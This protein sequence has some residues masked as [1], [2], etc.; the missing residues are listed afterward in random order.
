MGHPSL[1][2]GAASTGMYFST[3]ETVQ[4]AL[5]VFNALNISQIDT[6][7]RYPPT[8]HGRSEELLGEVGAASQGF[9]ISTK[10]LATNL[11]FGSGELEAPA[12]RKSLDR[13]FKCL[14]VD[15]VDILYCHQPDPTTPLKEQ[16]A[17]LND[18]FQK[19]SFKRLGVSNFSAKL[20]QE[21]IQICEENGFVKPSLLPILRAH[22]ISFFAFR[23]LAA[24]FLTGNFSAGKSDGTRFSDGHPL[25]KAFQNLYGA[26]RLQQ[27]MK[28]LETI[29]APL[30]ISGREASLKWIYHHSKLGDGD[31]II[32][33]ARKISQ[34]RENVMSISAGPLSEEVVQKIEGIW[35]LLAEDRGEIL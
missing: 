17:A 8:N 16:A 15:Q 34:I 29:L 14:G 27:A 5:E 26:P 19:G 13:S 23:A 25:G 3:K 30:G 12:I 11:N 21:F 2:F 4:D 28:N 32:L 1:I 9:S 33:G 10:I 22:L 31:G 18:H 35:D 20:L 7:G 24:G 6:A